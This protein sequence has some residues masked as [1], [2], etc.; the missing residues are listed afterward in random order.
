MENLEK[1]EPVEPFKDKIEAMLWI[2]EVGQTIDALTY[3]LRL[4]SS[5]YMNMITARQHMMLFIDLVQ[6]M[7][8]KNIEL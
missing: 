8:A 2:P 5:Y 3:A 1:L 6:W 4:N 7:K